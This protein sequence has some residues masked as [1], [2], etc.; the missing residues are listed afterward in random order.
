MSRAKKQLKARRRR[1]RGGPL[2]RGHGSPRTFD[3]VNDAADGDVLLLSYEIIDGPLHL[4]DEADPSFWRALGEHD[5]EVIHGQ[6]A[7]DPLR[8]VERLEPLLEKFPSAPMLLN[9]L[10]AAYT[11]LGLEHKSEEIVRL[12]YERNPNYLFARANYAQVCLARG[13]LDRVKEVFDNKFDLKLMYPRRNVFHVTEFA[14]FAAVAIEYFARTGE[15][16]AAKRLYEVVAQ[17]APDHPATGQARALL[18][19]SV[20]NRAL[21]RVRRQLTRRG[22]AAPAGRVGC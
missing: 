8:A 22:A 11:N 16:D 10:S 17:V 14:A 19:R 3:P 2:G 9:W 15:W 6:V 18:V 1:E 4:P 21:D 5:R 7:N 13:D 20:V 12:N